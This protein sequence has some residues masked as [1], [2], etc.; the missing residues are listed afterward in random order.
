MGDEMSEQRLSLDQLQRIR[1]KLN[2]LNNGS[3]IRD[4]AGACRFINERGFV[5]LMPIDGIPLP[6]LS[7]ADEAEAWLGFAITDR[8]WAWKETLPQQKLCAYTKLIHGRGTFIDWRLYPSFLK[9]YG[10]DG[11]PEYEY[12]NGRLDRTERDLYRIVAT[13]GPID[14]REL[15]VRAKSIFDGKRQRFT[16]ALERLQTRFYLTVAGGSLEGWTLHIWDLVERQAPPETLV[17]LPSAAAARANILQ[18]T[19]RNCHAIPER[20]LRSILRWPQMELQ[21]SIRTMKNNGL[22]AEVEVGGEASSWLMFNE[23]LVNEI[24]YL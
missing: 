15:W 2:R 20:K 6:S 23:R 14:S 19:I 9:V 10:P 22:I 18:Q 7:E 3:R 24:C 12:E 13:D 21:E 16:A 11:D 5:L 1:T 4:D 17:N 8:A